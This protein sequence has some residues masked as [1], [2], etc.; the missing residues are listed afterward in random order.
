[1]K[2][3]SRT[4]R[5]LPLAAW[6]SE[7][8]RTH[9]FA[10]QPRDWFAVSGLARIL[11]GKQRGELSAKGVMPSERAFHLAA[12]QRNV[13]ENTPATQ[14]ASIWEASFPAIEQQLVTRRFS[15]IGD[16]SYGIF[17]DQLIASEQIDPSSYPSDF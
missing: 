16:T 12:N 8:I 7:R 11:D 9:S 13:F 1:M 17:R 5:L 3:G 15:T 4:L 2:S 10:S 6:R 14:N